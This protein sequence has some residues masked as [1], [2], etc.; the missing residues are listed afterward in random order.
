M[1]TKKIV[2]DEN[3]ESYRIKQNTVRGDKDGVK[4]RVV[5]MSDEYNTAVLVFIGDWHIGTVDFDIDGAINVLNYVLQTPNALL[6]CLGDMMNTAILNSVSDIF[7]DIAYPREQWEVFVSLLKQ[8]KDKLVVVHTGNHERR[9][10]KNTGLDP[11]EEATK[12]MDAEDAYAPYFADTY[13]KLKQG[14][15]PF[16]FPVVTHHGDSGNPENNSSVNQGSMIN[17]MGHTHQFKNYTITKII[18]NNN[19]K[20]VKKP[21]LNIVI[22]ASGGGEYG[23]SKGYKP[24]NKCPYYA[25]E[26][27]PVKN[28]LYDKNNPSNMEPPVT[29]ATKSIP[30]LSKAP[31]TYKEACIELGTDI[32]NK[33]MKEA[34]QKL[35]PLFDQIFDIIKETGNNI[36]EELAEKMPEIEK[37]PKPEVITPTRSDTTNWYIYEE[38]KE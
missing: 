13:I 7:E 29:L 35:G 31:S 5:D 4:K 3:I 8:V 6:F 23:F 28:P 11:V 17:G 16:A 38:S 34:K 33:N 36:N 15:K 25:I 18:I 19:G 12:A 21:E 14:N 27:T 32:I 9:V 24:I 20:R 10:K 26:V 30:I 37:D 2:D 22:P 1:D